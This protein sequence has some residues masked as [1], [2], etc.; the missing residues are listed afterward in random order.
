MTITVNAYLPI[1]PSYRALGISAS[2]GSVLALTTDMSGQA[3]CIALLASQAITFMVASVYR[4]HQGKHSCLLDHV[5]SG[6]LIYIRLK[7]NKIPLLIYG[8]EAPAK[9]QKGNPLTQAWLTDFLKS[10]HLTFTNVDDIEHYKGIKPSRFSTSN[11]KL[12]ADGEDVA[13]AGLRLGYFL[14]NKRYRTPKLYQFAHA[15]SEE[16]RLG[17]HAL[18]EENP[19]QH[20]LKRRINKKVNDEKLIKNSN[21]EVS[22]I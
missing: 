2:I 15:E 8:I 13:L 17:I 21:G 5:E 1:N 4:T 18:N 11:R 7:G 3:A 9:S 22:W 20:R 16:K 10:K 12:Y 6:K 14:I 19:Y